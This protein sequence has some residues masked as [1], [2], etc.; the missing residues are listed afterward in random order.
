[1]E[2]VEVTVI[3]GA[4]AP[5]RR[6]FAE[7]R[8]AATQAMLLSAARLAA[9]PDPLREAI[10]LVPWSRS[11]GGVV[12]EF[13]ADTR[14]TEVIGAFAAESE[15]M[16]LAR[17]VCVVDA[18]HFFSDLLRDDYIA[19]RGGP[20]LMARAELLVTQMEYASQIVWVNWE[21]LSTA[22]LSALMALA[23]HIAPSARLRLQQPGPEPEVEA[24]PFPSHQDRAGWIKLLNGEYDTYMTDTRVS[25]FRYTHERPLQPG[26]LHEV[27]D[28]RIEPGEFGTLVRSAGFCRL[29]TRPQAVASWDHVGRVISFEPVG[30]DPLT[31]GAELLAIGQDLALI[32]LDLDRDAIS[33]ALDDAALTDAEFAAGPETWLTFPDPFPEW[34]T[35]DESLD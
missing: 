13:P 4:C 34:L 21:A 6:G 28:D 24:T 8:A 2:S 20:P 16:S 33:A 1:M 32:G 31:G 18:A 15:R 14:A 35:A 30:G 22:D 12:V 3:M 9:S 7:R 10:A 19:A 29:A 23:N 25:A 5:E 26:R 11:T 27:L 17:I